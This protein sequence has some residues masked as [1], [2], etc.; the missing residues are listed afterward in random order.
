MN[1]PAH[2]EHGPPPCRALGHRAPGGARPA[3]HALIAETGR[4]LAGYKLPKAVFL[5]D[6]LPRNAMGKVEKAKLRETYKS[7]FAAGASKS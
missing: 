5:V 3:E 4:H 1:H 2:Y 6:Q 7:T